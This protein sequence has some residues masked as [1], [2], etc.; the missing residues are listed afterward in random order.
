MKTLI[1]AYE[2]PDLDGTASAF[3]YNELKNKLGEEAIWGVFGKPHLEVEFTFNYLNLGM[4]Q[5]EPVISQV[6]NIILVDSS[7]TRGISQLIDINKVIELIDHRAINE[8]EKFVNATAQIEIVGACATL[9][10]EKFIEQ[11]IE[12][13][14]EAATMLFLAIASNTINFKAKVTTERDLKMA[15]YLKEIAQVDQSLI[16]QMFAYKSQLSGSIKSIL[17]DKIYHDK[18]TGSK[19]SIFQLE[20]TGVDDFIKN[21][22]T[23][24]SDAI[25]E[26]KSEQGFDWVLLTCIDLD[27]GENT[28]LVVD[29]MAEELIEDILKIRFDKNVAH[30][31]HIIMRKELIPLIKEYLER[32][33]ESGE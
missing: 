26:I 21:N 30:L 12:P 27:K 31:D 15:E 24:I 17:E 16:H 13:S 9:I 25:E 7:D 32:I 10:A 6:D 2:S 23:E 1:T 14:R 18:I 19:V 11:N 8:A 3:A 33:H 5:A 28:F 22:F 20:I 29:D 4:N